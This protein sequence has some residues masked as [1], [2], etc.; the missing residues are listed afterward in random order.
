MPKQWHFIFEI[1]I[2]KQIMGFRMVDCPVQRL[3]SRVQYG[4]THKA[5]TAEMAN[6]SNEAVHDVDD[7]ILDEFLHRPL[8]RDEGYDGEG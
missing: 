1:L 6:G 8:P 4:I 7:D 5:S 3:W 2:G